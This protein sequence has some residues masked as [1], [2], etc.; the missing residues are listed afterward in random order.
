MN[1]MKCL[2]VLEIQI[3]VTTTAG[4]RKYTQPTKEVEK[5]RV[6]LVSH[7]Y[8]RW[9]VRQVGQSCYL[10][11]WTGASEFMCVSRMRVLLLLLLAECVLLS[12]VCQ[13]QAKGD[14]ACQVV[15]TNQNLATN[16]GKNSKGT[17]N[18][19]VTITSAVHVKQNMLLRKT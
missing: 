15:E 8:P 17:Q 19:K 3:Q 2:P 16:L 9:Q 1:D 18:P 14:Q 4:R 11:R 5:H 7:V 6:Y 12:G 13:D 10:D